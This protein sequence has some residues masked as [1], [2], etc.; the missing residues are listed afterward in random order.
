[1]SLVY[2][3]I[4]T[5]SDPKGNLNISLLVMFLVAI[6]IIAYRLIRKQPL[7]PYMYPNK[8]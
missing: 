7:I 5:S 1:M 3:D 4:M 6:E 2:D 8:N